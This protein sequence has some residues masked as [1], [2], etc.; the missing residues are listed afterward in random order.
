MITKEFISDYDRCLKY[1]GEES[2]MR[3]CIEEMSEL[4]KELC[5]YIRYSKF[6]SSPELKQKLKDTKANIIEE[7]ADVFNTLE[8]LEH[9]FGEQEVEKIRKSKMKRL[10]GLLNNWEKVNNI[11]K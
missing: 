3:M 4:T 8:Q 10:N 6:E 1:W 7:I 11:T 2:E 5:K 9:I